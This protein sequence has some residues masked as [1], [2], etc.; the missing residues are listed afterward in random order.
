MSPELTRWLLGALAA[1]TIALLARRRRSLTVDG[2]LAAT[3]MGTVIVGTAGWW[4]GLLLVAFFLSS[5]I[6]S[7]AG[8]APPTLSQARGAE[9]DAVQVLAN[10]GIALATAIMFSVSGAAAWIVAL[11]G[12]LAAT[13]ADTWST[14]IG[15]TS[16]A[17]PRLITTWRPVPTGTSGAVSGRG[18]AGALGGGA[19]IGTLAAFGWANDLLPG[20]IPF[21]PALVA[22]ATGGVA[23]SLVD[24]LLGATIQDQRWCDTCQKGTEQKTHRCGTPT[25]SIRG[26]AWIDNDV[27]NVSCAITGAVVASTLVAMLA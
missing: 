6:L 19:L 2:A 13:N 21:L 1:G 17:L 25:R 18:L 23:G 5:S 24:S 26:I 10:G 12:S 8:Q 22:I 14:E 9:R 7:H 4:S 3:I 16:R 11:A 20:D 27:V 15:R